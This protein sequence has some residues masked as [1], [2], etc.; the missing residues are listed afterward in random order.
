MDQLCIN[1]NNPREKQHEVSRMRE[2][3][4]N[5]SATL[6]AIHESIGEGTV[7]RLLGSFEKGKSGLIY[8]NQIIKNSLPI[9]KKIIDS[10]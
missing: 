10:N 1:Q 7:K 5:S 3:Y 2:Y 6:V 4:G 9:L 8:P